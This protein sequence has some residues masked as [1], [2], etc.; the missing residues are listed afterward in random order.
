MTVYEQRAARGMAAVNADL[1][2]GW[3]DDFSLDAFWLQDPRLCV[4]GQAYRDREPGVTGYSYGLDRLSGLELDMWLARFEFAVSCGFTASMVSA[5]GP[6]EDAWRTLISEQ[7]AR[8]G[9]S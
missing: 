5:F 4:L 6:L 1:G 8:R 2:E 3:V 9:V 7:K